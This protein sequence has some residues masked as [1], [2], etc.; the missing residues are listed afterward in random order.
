MFKL[1]S[2]LITL[3][4]F[5]GTTS[6]AH[7]FTAVVAAVV[8]AAATVGA[9]FG[10]GALLGAVLIIGTVALATAALKRKRQQ[11][12][13]SLTGPTGVLITKSGSSA[14][15]PVVYG[16]RRIAGH[17]T[18]INSD[19][20][21][22]ANL[23]L[24]ETLCE[25]PIEHLDKVYFND[26]LVATAT[27]SSGSNANNFTIESEYSGKVE[28]Y[29]YDGSQTAEASQT[30]PGFNDSDDTKVGKKVAED[31]YG[32]GA[33]TI[34]YLIK[35]KKVPA[36]GGVESNDASASLTFSANPA[37]C[38]YD[39][40]TNSLYGKAIPKDLLDTTTFNNAKTYS[41][42][43]V[44]KTSSDNTQVTRYECN[45]FL[46]VDTS[47]LSNLQELLTTCRAGLITGDTYKLIVD[48]PVTASGVA[49]NDDNIV[50]SVNFSQ[51]N[52]KTL[53]NSLK[54][55]FPNAEGTFNYQ[56]DIT[57]VASSTLQGSSHDNIVLN[58]DMQLNHTTNKE[59]AERI[60]LE[61]INQSRQSGIVE[62]DVDP[63]LIDLTVGDVVTFTNATLGQTNKTYR[64]LQTVVKPDHVITLNMRE[65]DTNVYWDNNKTFITS[66][67]D[68]TDH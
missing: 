8:Q 62:V 42:E 67:K 38:I 53:L 50:G 48:E 37:R 51:A 35:G 9:I 61:E 10:G 30:I 49:I 26:E 27:T 31:V 12:Q 32:A 28:I 47:V 7:A 17:R 55:S 14:G 19:G 63:S 43:T 57:T 18:F 65:Y 46:D 3:A 11:Q 1:K 59:M 45:A 56:E 39:Y 36:I 6:Q 34:T 25:G 24:V 54:V 40:L 4:I 21:D 22:N 13:A 52:K 60:A 66:N 44:D 29:F 16:T 5:L 58:Q 64:I 68:D 20:T 15:I 23:H 33:P 2:F 41:D